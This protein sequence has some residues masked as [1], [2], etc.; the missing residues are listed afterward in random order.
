M[1]L[2][3]IICPVRFPSHPQQTPTSPRAFSLSSL[4]STYVELALWFCVLSLLLMAFTGGKDISSKMSCTCSAGARC[5]KKGKSETLPLLHYPVSGSLKV[6]YL[7]LLSLDSG[8]SSP[9]SSQFKWRGE[10]NLYIGDQTTS[11]IW[12]G[13]E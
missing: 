13:P 8:F 3:C 11:H 7:H 2:L 12:E 10:V 6:S 4:L 9:P 5:T 1:P